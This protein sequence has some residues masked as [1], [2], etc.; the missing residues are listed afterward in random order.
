MS[1]AEVSIVNAWHEAVNRGDADRAV[2]LA[3]SD[4]VVGGPKGAARGCDSLRDWVAGAGIHL[5]ALR[6]F[7]RG[8]TV[9]VEQRAHWSGP[10]GSQSEPQ[11]VA[12]IFTLTDGLLTGIVRYP[13][14]ASALD[15]SGLSLADELHLSG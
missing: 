1:T 3:S 10:D 13:D 15:A 5:E 6:V 2:S 9:V 4:V 14:L 12:S 8:R 11:I 7:Q